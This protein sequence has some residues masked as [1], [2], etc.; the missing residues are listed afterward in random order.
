[1]DG[2]KSFEDVV[3]TMNS[4]LKPLLLAFRC[5]KDEFSGETIW[6]V[7]NTKSDELFKSATPYT[8]SEIVFLKRIIDH[9]M[10]S[11]NDTYCINQHE[12]TRLSKDILTTFT[13]KA[14]ESALETFANDDWLV[15]F[16]SGKYTLGTRA[17]L[18]LDTY[19]RDQFPNDTRECYMC[20][21]ICIMGEMCNNCDISMHKL[22]I[23][24]LFKNGTVR[25]AACPSCNEPWESINS[26]G[27]TDVIPDRKPRSA[28]SSPS[29][30]NKNLG[31]VEYEDDDSNEIQP[32][33][34]IRHY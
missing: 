6:A 11:S 18:D 30:D 14:A 24:R 26:F 13:Y 34:K 23:N 27:P 29:A 22:C 15:S 4:L 10:S 17:L 5:R 16:S 32:P 12:A 28:R 31:N 20:K 8:P 3:Q 25:R 33:R 21:D 1:M 19:L 2:D 7:V 9:I